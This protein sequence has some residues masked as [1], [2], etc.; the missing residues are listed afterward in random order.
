ML[1]ADQQKIKS[2]LT[3]FVEQ[4]EK[5]RSV[6]SS[7][8]WTAFKTFYDRWVVSLH[9]HHDNEE[10][11]AFPYLSDVKHAF[12][13]QKVTSDHKVLLC[14]LEKVETLAKKVKI[15]TGRRP[16]EEAKALRALLESFTLLDEALV[17]HFY[18]EEDT[19]LPHLRKNCTVKEIQKHVTKPIVAGMGWQD[20]GQYFG[21]LKADT[22]LKA[23]MKQEGIPFFVKWIFKSNISKYNRVYVAP[24]DEAVEEARNCVIAASSSAPAISAGGH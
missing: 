13:K 8:Q 10:K 17:E 18:E 12:D 1:I 4:T 22:E 6:L 14:G 24:L 19:F 3:A 5:G 2:A 7:Q 11:I 16:E 9:H 15:G 23:F 20:R 21:K